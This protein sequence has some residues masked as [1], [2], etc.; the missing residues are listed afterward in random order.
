MI[1]AGAVVTKD[2]P[3]FALVIGV[4]AQVVG[5]VCACGHALHDQPRLP[6]PGTML[7]CKQCARRYTVTASRSL[8]LLE[9]ATDS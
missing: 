3:A 9:I 8:D 6:A 7:T 1:G 5:W 4:P 2:V